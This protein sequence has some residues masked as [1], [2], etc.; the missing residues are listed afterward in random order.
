MES[1][2]IEHTNTHQKNRMTSFLGG[3]CGNVME[4]DVGLRDVVM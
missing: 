2:V 4:W 3:E 1:E